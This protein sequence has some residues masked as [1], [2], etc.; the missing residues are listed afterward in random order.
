[1]SFP[2]KHRVKFVYWLVSKLHKLAMNLEA[3]IWGYSWC[4]T[5]DGSKVYPNSG[6]YGQPDGWRLCPDCRGD[7]WFHISLTCHSQ[8]PSKC[9]CKGKSKGLDPIIRL[10]TDGCKIYCP[11][12][13]KSV[14]AKK[15]WVAMLKWNGTYYYTKE[16][17]KFLRD[18]VYEIKTDE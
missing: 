17:V 8:F 14:S 16:N 3:G 9:Y 11:G 1:M 12:C 7:R 15:E 18:T 10:Y 6:Y 4:K 13:Q 5:C 2:N